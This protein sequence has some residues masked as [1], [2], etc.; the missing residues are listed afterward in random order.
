LCPPNEVY[1]QIRYE[2]NGAGKSH[3][4]VVGYKD[5]L[6]DPIKNPARRT[7]RWRD[8]GRPEQ[9]L[10][11]IQFPDDGFMDYG[12][13]DFVPQHTRH[14]AYRGT[15][16]SADQPVLGS[17]VGYEIDSFDPAYPRPR[18]TQYTL[19]ASSPFLNFAGVPYTHNM[20]I[21]RGTGGN[22]VWASG[23]VDWAWFLAEGVA[24]NSVRD[25]R[26]AQRMT[27]NILDRMIA[28]RH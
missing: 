28:A 14:W 12:G 13:Q 16:F 25:T 15:Q 5:F 27:S 9:G 1:W 8:V 22:W 21:Y 19:L 11:G 24:T 2:A 17:I 26:S 7:I 6:P 3:R 18:G 10:V 20:S 4:I 23:S